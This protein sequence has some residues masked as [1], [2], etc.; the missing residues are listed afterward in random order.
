MSRAFLE[1]MESES[2]RFQSWSNQTSDLKIGVLLPDLTLGIIM[3]EKRT[4]WFSVR[5]M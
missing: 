4:G 3:I 2:R 1:I 5:T